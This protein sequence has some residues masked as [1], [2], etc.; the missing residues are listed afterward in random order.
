MEY[1]SGKPVGDFT[2]GHLMACPMAH[3]TGRDV[4]CTVSRQ[5]ANT[6]RCPVGFSLGYPMRCAIWQWI[7]HEIPHWSLRGGNHGALVPLLV[8]PWDTP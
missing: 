5:T 2:M 8:M 3:T 1:P 6:M 7:S 4:G